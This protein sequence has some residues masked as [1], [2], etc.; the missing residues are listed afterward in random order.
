MLGVFDGVGGWTAEGVDAGM[1]ARGLAAHC[2]TQV[3][4]RQ[5]E[6]PQLVLA[7]AHALTRLAGSAT[8]LVVQIRHGVSQARIVRALC[9]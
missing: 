3:E 7:A 1:Y 5:L 9:F 4:E 2:R 8:A 6:D